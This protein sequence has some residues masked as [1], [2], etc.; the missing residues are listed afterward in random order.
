MGLIINFDYKYGIIL[1]LCSTSYNLNRE[2]GGG[3]CKFFWMF[4]SVANMTSA[5]PLG[6]ENYE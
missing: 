2:K 5:H 4:P 3:A 6:G 1:L